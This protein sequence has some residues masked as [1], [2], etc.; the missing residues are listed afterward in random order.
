M[1]SSVKKVKDCRMRLSVEVEPERFENRYQEVLRDFQKGASLPGFREGKAPLSMVEKRYAKE[2]EEETLKT[3][4]PEVYHQCV[5]DAKLAPVSLPSISEVKLERGKKLAFAAEFDQEPEFKL[6]DYK[7]IK[8]RKVASDVTAEEAEKGMQTLLESRAEM[9]PLVEPRAVKR[10]DFLVTDIE[11][12]QD[13][14]YV[15]GKKGALLYAEPNADDDFF[16]KVV[17]ANLDEVREISADFSPEDKAKGLVG[18]RP[19]YKIWIRGIKEKKLPA[20]DEEFAKSF[21]KDSVESLR[22]AVHK[23]LARHK[24]G[25]SHAKM[26]E[27]LFSKLLKLADF[28]VPESLVEKQKERLFDQ[29]RRHYLQMGVPE[30]RFEA[31]KA[32]ME[33][34]ARVKAVEQVRLY[35]ILQKVAELEGITE[36]EMELA[37]RLNAL[38]GESKRPM[39]EVRRVFEDDLRES[40]REKKTVDFLLANAKFEDKE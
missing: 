14:R 13:G 26:K 11:I 8:L 33:G 29:A 21:G 20:L 7:G 22:E 40:L 24:A 17:G 27:E 3:L 1:K 34:E 31:E 5:V 12:F 38:A 19:Y 28:A 36:D 39:E 10:G 23:D 2:A 35:F 30:S 18:R 37:Q 6:K 9:T 25:E 15:P 4:I 16:E 32:G